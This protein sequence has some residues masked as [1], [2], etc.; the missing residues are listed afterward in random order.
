M[1]PSQS[2][3]SES[4]EH[5]SHD[6]SDNSQISVSIKTVDDIDELKYSSVMKLS[7][8][9]K[10]Y[11]DMCDRIEFPYTILNDTEKSM[12]DIVPRLKTACRGIETIIDA[13]RIANITPEDR[14]M[15]DRMYQIINDNTIQTPP[16]VIMM[17]GYIIGTYNLI[18]NSSEEVKT[19]AGHMRST[20]QAGST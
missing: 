2:T 18:H 8:L 6:E 16:Q 12:D 17:A 14:L 15:I 1:E 10:Y 9:L 20:G 19:L 11:S 3:H 4:N 13:A 5:D 7:I